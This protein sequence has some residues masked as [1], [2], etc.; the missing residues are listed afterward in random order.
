MSRREAAAGV[1]VRQCMG[2]MNRFDHRLLIRFVNSGGLAV[3]D[4]EMKAQTRGAY[5]CDNPV[6][7]SKAVRSGRLRAKLSLSGPPVYLTETEGAGK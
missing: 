6:C 1:C 7:L 2:C 5:V 3:R 4:P